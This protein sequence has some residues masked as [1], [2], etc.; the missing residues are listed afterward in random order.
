MA[1]ETALTDSVSPSTSLSLAT[2]VA[3]SMT[4][5]VSSVPEAPSSMAT[6]SSLTQVTSTVACA[7]SVL[8][9]PSSTM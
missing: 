7:E 1:L 2:R 9:S 3:P 6:G 5:S 4:T 8:P